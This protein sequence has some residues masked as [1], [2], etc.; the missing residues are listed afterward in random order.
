MAITPKMTYT[1]LALLGGSAIAVAVALT[2]PSNEDDRRDGSPSY[3]LRLNPEG[4]YS[5]ANATYALG[6]DDWGS[7][8]GAAAA[9]SDEPAAND[10][11]YSE[12][13][14][15]SVSPVDAIPTAAPS[16]VAPGVYECYGQNGMASGAFGI[17]DGSTY[18]S[19]NGMS[20][21]YTFDV[22]SGVLALDTE[23]DPMRYQR[24]SERSFR[25]I[26]PATGGP[27]GFVCPLNSS[28]DPRTPP[29]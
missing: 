15:D 29:W 3:T 7:G 22:A 24:I 23:S 17:V 14:A 2:R 1:M 4:S 20:G 25:V 19:S 26:N 9:T 5:G 27:G 6:D 18:M 11:G 21:R 28:K 8:A 10:G 13:P 12:A 16:G